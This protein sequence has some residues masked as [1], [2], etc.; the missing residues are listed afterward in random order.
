MYIWCM[1]KG[2]IEK[3]PQIDLRKY[4]TSLLLPIKRSLLHIAS[5]NNQGY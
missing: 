4:G 3:W 1:E 2:G 5:F